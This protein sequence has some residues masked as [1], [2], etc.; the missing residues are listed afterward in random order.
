MAR[1]RDYAAEYARRLAKGRQQGKTR[2]QAR[3]H[4]AG[5]HIERA[6]RE[7]A[8]FGLTRAEIARVR[9]W[10][11]ARLAVIS[12]HRSDPQD[13]VD[14]A[15]SEGYEWFRTYRDTWNAA[16]RTYIRELHSGTYSSRGMG[17]LEY[18]AD[19]PP[20]PELEWMYYH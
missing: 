6:E 13:V 4:R 1:K 5:E 2:Q 7:R 11:T 18:L 20:V 19:I 10:A 17:F 8:E 15:M 12:D 3:G 9:S 14:Q 16:R